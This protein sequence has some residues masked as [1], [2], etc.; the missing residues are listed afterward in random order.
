MSKHIDNEAIDLVY[1]WVDDSFPGYQEQLRAYSRNDHDRNPN[2]TRDNLELLRYSLRSTEQYLPWVRNIYIVSCRPQIPEWLNTMADNITIVHHDEIMEKRHLPTFNSF[3]IVSYIHRI[4]GLSRYFLYVEDDMLFGR[5][6][7]KKDFFDAD[8]NILFYPR[9]PLLLSTH[10]NKISPESDSPWNHTQINTNNILNNSFGH[11]TRRKI[12]HSPLMIDKTAW[13]EIEQR[14]PEPV[15]STRSSRF[16]G[17]NNIAMELLYPYFMIYTKRGK[18]VKLWI[19]YLRSFYF[20]I[21]NIVILAYTVTC[22]MSFFK[23]RYIT[24]NDNMEHNPN[25]MVTSIIRRFLNKRYQHA[26][27]YEA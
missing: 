27:K 14:W 6:L 7:S 20:G 4:P 1:T 8:G 17:N 2:R 10:E 25:P 11:A 18:S 21:E 12:A 19:T 24:L 23:T 13:A 22:I 16:R 15:E 9:I 3:A 5:A 26:S